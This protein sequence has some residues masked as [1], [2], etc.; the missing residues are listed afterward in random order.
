MSTS[1][2]ARLVCSI[3]AFEKSYLNVYQILLHYL[4]LLNNR[5]YPRFRTVTSEKKCQISTK[6]IAEVIV[7]TN[8]IGISIINSVKSYK[9]VKIDKTKIITIL[10][11]FKIIKAI[12]SFLRNGPIKLTI[13]PIIIRTTP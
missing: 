13:I 1:K 5:T 6:V 12:I 9:V 4:N 11:A 7:S 2:S 8:E 10:I 3:S